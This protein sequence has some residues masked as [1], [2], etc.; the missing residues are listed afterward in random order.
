[1]THDPTIAARATRT[2]QMKDGR[3]V[4]DQRAISNPA[5]V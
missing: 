4:S 3:I 5:T 1:V 2:L